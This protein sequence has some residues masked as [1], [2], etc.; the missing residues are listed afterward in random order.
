MRSDRMAVIRQRG[1]AG[2]S[3]VSWVKFAG[4]AEFLW[5]GG[6]G[7]GTILLVGRPGRIFVFFDGWWWP[8][9]RP[10]VK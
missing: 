6:L 5:L 8:K 3:A 2:G 9:E 10:K 4:V 7:V 1:V